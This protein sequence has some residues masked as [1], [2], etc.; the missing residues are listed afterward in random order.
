MNEVLADQGLCPMPA[1]EAVFERYPEGKAQLQALEFDVMTEPD[2]DRWIEICNQPAVRKWALRVED[3]EAGPYT[4]RDAEIDVAKA[5]QGW[6]IG[7]HFSY[8]IRKEAELVGL[9]TL[10]SANRHAASLGYWADTEG[11]RGYMTNAVIA[12]TGIARAAGYRRL[13]IRTRA[14][15]QASNAVARRADFKPYK[16]DLASDNN[17]YQKFL[18]PEQTAE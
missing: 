11:S 5:N 13:L 7:S 4:P 17:Y 18:T 10:Q 6:L 2:F 12:T 3:A 15:N 1:R 14:A 16:H 9:I 8:L